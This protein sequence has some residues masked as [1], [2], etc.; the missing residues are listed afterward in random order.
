MI[1]YPHN[2]S[3]HP[4]PSQSRASPC[5]CL[6]HSLSSCEETLNDF[7]SQ[8]LSPASLSSSRLCTLTRMHFQVVNPLSV[9][10]HRQN[11]LLG[12]H[13]LLYSSV[14]STETLKK[15][16]VSDNA[17]SIYINIQG[18][19]WEWSWSNGL[20]PKLWWGCNW[21]F[22]EVKPQLKTSKQVCDHLRTES[23]RKHASL[24]V[25]RHLTDIKITV[26]TCLHDAFRDSGMFCF[27]WPSFDSF[28]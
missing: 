13:W 16:K 3:L 6:C 24:N 26:I 8:S 20:L 28:I 11:V 7:H 10:A 22:P 23:K 4:P 14:A 17:N 5:Q 21:R 15:L 19:L 12:F 9:L 2:L 25:L 18:H 1:K 27:S